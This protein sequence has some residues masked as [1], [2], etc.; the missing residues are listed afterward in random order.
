[1]N[2][3]ERLKNIHEW[4]VKWVMSSKNENFEKRGKPIRKRGRSLL[5]KHVTLMPD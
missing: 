1:M 4:G 5:G 3:A 2:Y